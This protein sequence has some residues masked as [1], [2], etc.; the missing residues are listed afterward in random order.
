MRAKDSGNE[1][2]T[3]VLEEFLMAN[4]AQ[5][6]FVACPA[7]RLDAPS[8]TPTIVQPLNHSVQTFT[9]NGLDPIAHQF[10]EMGQFAVSGGAQTQTAGIVIVDAWCSAANQLSILFYNPTGGALTPAAGNYSLLVF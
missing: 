1:R 2:G 3:I 8:L 10:L 4:P 6:P 5:V 9:V 7:Q